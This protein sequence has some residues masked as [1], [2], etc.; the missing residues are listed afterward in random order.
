MGS[1]PW[2]G[3]EVAPKFQWP[4]RMFRKLRKIIINNALS[5][6]SSVSMILLSC[7]S[8]MA[9]SNILHLFL[10]EIVNTL[11]TY[12]RPMSGDYL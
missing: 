5:V 2:N 9:I 10:V 6:H 3:R 12:Y 4:S 1:K 8:L 7:S 11:F